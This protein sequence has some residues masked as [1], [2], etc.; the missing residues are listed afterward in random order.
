MDAGEY[1]LIISLVGFVTTIVH[2]V[3]ELHYYKLRLKYEHEKLMKFE[4]SDRKRKK[5]IARRR[6]G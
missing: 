5:L 4:E 6:D 1:A 3:I 2:L